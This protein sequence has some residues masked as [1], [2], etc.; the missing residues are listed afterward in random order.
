[1]LGEEPE[2]EAEEAKRRRPARRLPDAFALVGRVPT[3][4]YPT[5]VD[6]TPPRRRL[7]WVSA[8]GLGVGPNPNGPN[9]LDPRDSDDAINSFQ[10]LPSQVYGRSGILDFPTNARLRRLTP[11]ASRQIRPVNDERP[12]P[13]TPITAPGP[14]QKIEHV[15]YV[16]R[17]NRTYDQVLGDD[18]RGDGDP[19]LTLFGDRI[20]PNAHALGRRFPLLDHV[21]ANSEASIDGHFWTSAAAVSDYVVKSWNANYG[22]QAAALRLRRLRGH[23]AVAALP[24]RPGGEAGDLVLQL[25]RGDRRRDL[26][27]ARQGP[28]AGGARAEP[29]QAGQLRPERAGDPGRLL[30]E[31]RVVG[32]HRR[33]ALARPAAGP[34]GLRL[35]AP[36]RGAAR[37]DVALR[38]LQAALPAAGGERERARVQLHDLRQRPHRRHPPGAAHAQRDD[39][40]ERLRARPDRRPDLALADLGQVADPRDRGRL[41]GR[42]RPRRRAPHPRLRDLLLREAR[43]RRAHALRL[44]VVH[45]DARDRGRA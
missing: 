12:P 44:P 8:K 32:R 7:V 5:A 3:G 11:R 43:R 13:G 23:L 21:Y 6:A 10:Y 20:T 14:G 27:A 16:V 41:S 24:L 19:K 40:R 39:R 18:P 25:R 42:R 9:P 36:A 28:R 15:F 38:L 17:E 22:G 4:S 37:R 1:M 31:R 26:P 2:E 35:V 33:G 30:P 45:P 29:R 34:R